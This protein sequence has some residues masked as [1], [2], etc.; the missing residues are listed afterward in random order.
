MVHNMATNGNALSI[1]ANEFLNDIFPNNSTNNSSSGTYQHNLANRTDGGIIA[2]W[3]SYSSFSQTFDMLLHVQTYSGDDKK[4]GNEVQ[5]LS[6]DLGWPSSTDE[7]AI[8]SLGDDG[9]L[10]SRVGCTLLISTEQ[11]SQN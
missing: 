6:T 1:E 3:M 2:S 11:K 5:V 8:I 4:L 9:F 7:G 10:V